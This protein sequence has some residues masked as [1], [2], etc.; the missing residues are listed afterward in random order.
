MMNNQKVLIIDDEKANLKFLRDI[1][2]DE[3]EVILAKDG[4]QGIKKAI[5]FRPDLIL[6]DVVMPVM[7]GFEVIEKLKKEA[8]TS[9]IPV[10]FVTGELEVNKE[11]RGLKLGAC[12]YIQKPFDDDIV[13]ARV[14][15]HL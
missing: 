12:D 8:E 14:K 1:L 15:L 4:N 6:L 11:E 9:A 3:V 2:K 7:D 10:I 13:L 5:E